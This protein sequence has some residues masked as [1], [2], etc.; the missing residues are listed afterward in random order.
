ME[1]TF[2]RFLVVVQIADP[3]MAS[4]PFEASPSCLTRAFSTAPVLRPTLM[5]VH[6]GVR[7]VQVPASAASAA[8][9]CAC[10]TKICLCLSASLIL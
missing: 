3:K 5:Q 10:A 6:G 8:W 9:C 7:R 1:L 4:F 2:V